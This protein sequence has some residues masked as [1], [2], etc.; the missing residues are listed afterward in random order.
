MTGRPAVIIEKQNN[1][2]TPAAASAADGGSAA[3]AATASFSTAGGASAMTKAR[4][5]WHSFTAAVRIIN[6]HSRL[7]E[8]FADGVS[9]VD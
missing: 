2:I 3:G 1:G 5:I 9:D 8:I 6:P 4:N 7:M